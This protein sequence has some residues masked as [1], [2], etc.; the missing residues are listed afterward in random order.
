MASLYASNYFSCTISSSVLETQ[1]R[2]MMDRVDELNQEA[3]KF[4]R[5]QVQVIRQ[6]QDKHRFT[7]K[8]VNYFF[9]VTLNQYC[10]CIFP[11]DSCFVSYVRPKR[12]L[13]GLLRE[14]HHY[15]K[16]ILR[17]SSGPFQFL[18]VSIP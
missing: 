11:C 13:L 18:L 15:L 2:S 8:R 1:L 9:C 6:Q 16:R 17:N 10:Q 14:S 3:I 7:L 4:N 5:F 12:M